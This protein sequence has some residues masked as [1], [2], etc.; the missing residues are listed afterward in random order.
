M[1]QFNGSVVKSIKTVEDTSKSEIDDKNNFSYGNEYL[2]TE[3]LLNVSAQL[4]NALSRRNSS[5]ETCLFLKILKLKWKKS[6]CEV[7]HGRCLMM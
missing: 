1:V 6:L 2:T 7:M 3:N 5:S 4:Y